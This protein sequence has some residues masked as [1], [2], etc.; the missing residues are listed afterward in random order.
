MDY[1]VTKAMK[2]ALNP[3]CESSST[4]SEEKIEILKVD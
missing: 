2:V 1:A 4:K 3:L